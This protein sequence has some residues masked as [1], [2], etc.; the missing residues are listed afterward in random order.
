MTQSLKNLNLEIRDSKIFGPGWVWPADDVTAWKFFNKHT[1][2]FGTVEYHSATLPQEIVELLPLQQRNIVLQAGGNSGL[3]PKQYSKFFKKVITFEPDTRWFACLANNVPEENV[4][5]FQAC[6]GN[7]FTPL[8]LAP[9]MNVT[10]GASNLGAIQTV[11]DGEIPQLTIDSLQLD[12]DLIHLD[13]EG[14]EGPALLGAKETILRAKPL[15]VLETAG[16]GDAYGWPQ[17]KIDELLFSWGYKTFKSW[18]HDMAYKHH[19]KY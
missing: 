15:I 3:Y 17:N 1:H 13:I 9:N 7:N 11:L 5:K 12:I 10:G 16:M 4:Y 19:E 8:G 18:G 6:L 2:I 14:F